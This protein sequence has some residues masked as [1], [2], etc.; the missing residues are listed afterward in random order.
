LG[1]QKHRKHNHEEGVVL[2][3][4]KYCLLG[5]QLDVGEMLW[6]HRSTDNMLIV[7]GIVTLIEKNALVF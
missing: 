4:L 3:K 7:I 6:E 5:A 2:H 1:Q